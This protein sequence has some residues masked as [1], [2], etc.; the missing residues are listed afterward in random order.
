MGQMDGAV[1]LISGGAR[2]MGASHARLLVEEGASVVIGDVLDD[3]GAATAKELGD[4]AHFVHLDVTREEDWQQAVAATED[5]YG[6]VSLLVNNAGIVLY[7]AI[8]QM[9]PDDFRRLIDVNLTGV[10]LGMR[11]AIPSLRRA[12]GGTI[13]NLSSTAGMMGYAGIVAYVASKWAVRGM[14]KTA[15]MELGGDGIRVC[16]IH[17]GPI[18]TPM[19]EGLD[20]QMTATQPLPRFGEAEEVSQLVLFLAARA[21]YSTGAEFIID[22]G[23]LLGP[24]VD[25]PE[26]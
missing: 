18:R 5:R 22:G 8:E 15:A 23:A 17:P 3:E 13:V 14:T 6:P 2:G 1:A 21:T 24:V 26:E 16:S 25:L 4:A 19:T 9:E 10:F 12:G 11:A 20:E 7:G